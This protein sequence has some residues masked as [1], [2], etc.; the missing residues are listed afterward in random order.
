MERQEIIELF[1]AIDGIDES[2]ANAMIENGIDTLP[3][4]INTPNQSFL[5]LGIS[6]DDVK[7]IKE[8]AKE[9]KDSIDNAPDNGESDNAPDNGEKEYL[10][11]C[12][13]GSVAPNTKFSLG[14]P[15]DMTQSVID[16][17]VKNGLCKEIK[18]K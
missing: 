11:L 7:T 9:L 2:R 17:V 3:K 10:S 18:D 8:S 1:I 12:R 6:K 5:A 13:I 4:I 16:Y 14:N 15:K